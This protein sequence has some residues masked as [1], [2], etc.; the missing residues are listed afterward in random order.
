MARQPSQPVAEP[1]LPDAPRVLKLSGFVAFLS[2]AATLRRTG[3]G[4]ARVLCL[5][6]A[7]PSLPAWTAVRL[8]VA[9]RT[10]RG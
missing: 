5:A 9:C 8:A 3:A 4:Q 10:H 1:A 6:D 2:E 7:S